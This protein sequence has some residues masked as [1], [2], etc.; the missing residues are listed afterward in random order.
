M[1]RHGIGRQLHPSQSGSTPHDRVTIPQ[2]CPSRSLPLH[3]PRQSALRYPPSSQIGR[4]FTAFDAARRSFMSRFTF[5]QL[6]GASS[7]PITHLTRGPQI[8]IALPRDLR[9]HSAVS[10]LGGLRTPARARGATVMGPASENLHINGPQ[11]ASEPCPFI[12][13]IADIAV[14][15]LH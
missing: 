13:P 9:A 11:V 6:A 8:P 15:L 5:G 2:I 1:Q 3:R 7:A 14:R 4:Q 10:S 12:P